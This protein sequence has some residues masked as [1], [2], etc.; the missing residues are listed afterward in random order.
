MKKLLSV[1]LV[2][3][4]VSS[5]ALL[6]S[7]AV[8]KQQFSASDIT[9]FDTQTIILGWESTEEE[10]NERA[11]EILEKLKVYHRQYDIYHE[12]DGINNLKTVNDNAGIKPVKV[13][14]EIIDLLLYAKEMYD[15]TEGMTNVAMGSVLSIWHTYRERGL[16]DPAN[17]AL[18][19]MEKLKEA[20]LHTDIEKVIIDEEKSTVYLED[21]EMSLDVGA[22]AK[23]YAV[24]MAARYCEDKGYTGYALSVGG[25]VRCIGK[26]A[27]GEK[28][29][30]GIQ[31]PD[32]ASDEAYVSKVYLEREALVTSGDYQR[33]Y[34]V[35]GK[36]YHHI[37]DPKTLMPRDIFAAV[38]I[39]TDHSGLADALSTALFNMSYEEGL[40]LAEKEGFEAIW[41]YPDGTV[42][43]TDGFN[44]LTK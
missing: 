31:N 35:N 43:T 37:I 13:D 4:M 39:I 3:A 40:A 36:Q 15:L 16:A 24:E 41:V 8:K 42:K 17:A 23:G 28:W 34:T 38:S 26:K 18:P 30:I 2:V 14:R 11:D 25:N 44:K 6:S 21:P 20:A 32:L 22:V 7:C 27:S 29:E 1:I 5:L 12:Y 19:P 9:V 10:F 33:F